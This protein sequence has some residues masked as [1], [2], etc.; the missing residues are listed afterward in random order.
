MSR[1]FSLSYDS[2][3][4]RLT[5]RARE[6]RSNYNNNHRTKINYN[7]NNNIMTRTFRVQACVCREHA[8]LQQTSSCTDCTFVCCVHARAVMIRACIWIQIDTRY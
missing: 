3:G 1:P 7:N 6:A 8:S 5:E 4:T 2:R